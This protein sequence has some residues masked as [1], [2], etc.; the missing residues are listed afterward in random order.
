VARVDLEARFPAEI[1]A[2]DTAGELN[3]AVAAS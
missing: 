1:S 2:S 3:D